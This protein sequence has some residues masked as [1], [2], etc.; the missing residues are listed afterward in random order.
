[1]YRYCFAAEQKIRAVKLRSIFQIS[2]N[3]VRVLRV[4]QTKTTVKNAFNG[5]YF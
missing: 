3:K 1:M 2:E 5:E 4:N